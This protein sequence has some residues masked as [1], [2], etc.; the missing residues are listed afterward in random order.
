MKSL[1][2][3]ST[4]LA[5][6]VAL[7]SLASQ[8]ASAGHGDE[9][10]HLSHDLEEV[11]SGLQTEFQ[12]HYSHTTAYR[13]LLADAAGIQS[14]AEHIHRLAHDP[15]VSLHHLEADLQQLDELS[16]HLHDLVDRTDAGYYGHVHGHTGHVHELMASVTSVIHTMEREVFAMQRYQTPSC[17]FGGHTSA[18]PYQQ[19]PGYHGYGRQMNFGGGNIRFFFRP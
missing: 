17:E 19:A 10:I 5:T 2:S 3:K 4:L 9:L 7:S 13:H 8:T 15:R 18:S 16:H 1:L 14:R 12:A 11:A 6:V